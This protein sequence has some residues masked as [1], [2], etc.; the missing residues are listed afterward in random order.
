M[1]NKSQRKKDQSVQDFQKKKLK[2]GKGPV[3]A[4][5]Y[6][7]TSFS[8]KS[9]LIPD[10]CINDDK[11]NLLTNSKNQTLSDLLHQLKHY[12]A[13]T[14]RGTCHTYNIIYHVHS[15]LFQTIQSTRHYHSNQDAI[16]GLADMLISHPHLLNTSA[17][18]LI[19]NGLS[20]LFVDDDRIVRKTLALFCKD[21][22]T[23]ITTIQMTPFISILMAYIS[24]AM[25]HIYEDIRLDGLLFLD[26]FVKVYPE[27]INEYAEKVNTSHHY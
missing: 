10:Q 2:V 24:S 16:N 19:V 14:R 27:L 17:L 26:V 1:P 11:S 23:Q 18:S 7:N 6:T 4:D 15:L 21:F 25:N 8:A 12:S 20:K 13:H 5:S 9:I 22:F 3:K